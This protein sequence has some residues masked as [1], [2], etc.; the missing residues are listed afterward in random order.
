MRGGWGH[1][2][3]SV[4]QASACPAQTCPTSSQQCVREPGPNLGSATFP[5]SVTLGG[6]LAVSLPAF[7]GL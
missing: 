7:P 6:L 1:T 3:G 4:R 5:F 2:S